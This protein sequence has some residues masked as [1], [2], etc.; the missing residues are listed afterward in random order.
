MNNTKTLLLPAALILVF[1]FLIVVAVRSAGGGEQSSKEAKIAFEST[2]AAGLEKA[3]AEGKIV[4]V[5]FNADWCGPCQMLKKEAFTD[6]S[7]AELLSG[8]VPVSVDVDRPG[9][10]G[11]WVKDL[12]VNGIPDIVFLDADGKLIDRIVGY[13]GVSEFKSDVKKI[14]KKAS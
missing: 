14:L 5:D 12:G 2:I 11:K 3:K 7:V 9:E 13:G 8:V 10:D 6:S 4:M 1:G